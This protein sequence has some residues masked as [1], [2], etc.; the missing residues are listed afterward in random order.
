M[1]KTLDDVIETYEKKYGLKV[2][3]KN[4]VKYKRF[5]G[6]QLKEHKG[7]NLNEKKDYHYRKVFPYMNLMVDRLLLFSYLIGET[8]IVA[9]NVLKTEVK[10]IQG[11]ED[12]YLLRPA[13]VGETHYDRK[14]KD[15]GGMKNKTDDR[16]FKLYGRIRNTKKLGGNWGETIDDLGKDKEVSRHFG[17][18]IDYNMVLACPSPNTL[19]Q[20]HGGYRWGIKAV[21]KLKPAS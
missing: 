6:R 14:Y 1:P 4:K 17:Q 11:V 7:Y 8:P 16:L 9:G 19:T 15:K 3:K 13:E 10:K 21:D 20:S 5:L 12:L 18:R 2:T